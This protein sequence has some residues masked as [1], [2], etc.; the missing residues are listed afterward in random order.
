MEVLVLVCLM[1][2]AQPDCREGTAVANV[3]AP[4]PAAS[5]SGC[6]Q[7]GMLYAASSNLVTKGTYAKIVCQPLQAAAVRQADRRTDD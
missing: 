4:E 1:S 6:F 5:I 2:V 7:E 3:Y